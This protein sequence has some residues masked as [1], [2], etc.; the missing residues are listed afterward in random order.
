MQQSI[1]RLASLAA[2]NALSGPRFVRGVPSARIARGLAS[3]AGENPAEPPLHPL[4]AAGH[5][6]ADP[7]A[8]AS[9]SSSEAVFEAQQMEAAVGRAAA[10]SKNDGPGVPFGDDK[11][12]FDGPTPRKRAVL[13]RERKIKED[14]EFARIGKNAHMTPKQ[15]LDLARHFMQYTPNHPAITATV[16]LNIDVRKADQALRTSCT[17]PYGTGAKKRVAVFAGPEMA[18]EALAAGAEMAGSEELLDKIKNTNKISKI[19]DI[20]LATPDQLPVV[21]QVARVL[22]PK[23]LMPNEKVGTVTTDLTHDVPLFASRTLEIRADKF[24]IVHGRI[25]STKMADEEILA[26]FRALMKSIQ[27]N[28]PSGAKGKYI[29]AIY[30]STAQGPGIGIDLA[31][32]SPVSSHFMRNEPVPQ[33]R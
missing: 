18:G 32:G 1:R 2:A 5:A 23:G 12:T 31:Y 6:P 28:K 10:S 21:R 9:P 13:P 30:I 4:D 24:G 19:I 7:A 25:A 26:N 14:P 8:D 17:L 22:G 15:A 16:Q 29:T 3:S 27:D 20:V 33:K 11:P